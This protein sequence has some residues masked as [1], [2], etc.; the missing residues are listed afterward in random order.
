MNMLDPY[1]VLGVPALA[2]GESIK[3][4][5]RRMA[6]ECHPDRNPFD[7]TAEERFKDLHQAYATLSDPAKRAS[8]DLTWKVKNSKARNHDWDYNFD[9][10]PD[11]GEEFRYSH[12]SSGSSSYSHTYTDHA[13]SSHS[14]KNAHRTNFNFRNVTAYF[15]AIALSL[16]AILLS[17]G[18]IYSLLKGNSYDEAL[19]P[20]VRQWQLS[21][22]DT[23]REKSVADYKQFYS[24]SFRIGNDDYHGWMRKKLRAARSSKRIRVEITD[25][26]VERLIA[27]LAKISFDQF[28][29]RD[30]YQDFGR[31]TLLLQKEGGLW[32]I[33]RE[34]WKPASNKQN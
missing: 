34:E 5:Y 3:K 28:Y 31:K 9:M 15:F 23:A 4:A 14:Y 30:N 33:I 21:W 22:Q 6:F 27:N 12:T 10:G 25:I 7:P 26:K 13:S 11:F 8:Y 24:K 2:N 19:K 18:T 29:K 20:F 32:K 17:Y 16:A 1:E